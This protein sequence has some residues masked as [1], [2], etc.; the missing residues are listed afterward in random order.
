VE[1]DVPIGSSEEKLCRVAAFFLG[2]VLLA[3]LVSDAS[4]PSAGFIIATEPEVSRSSRR[5]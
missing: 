1:P 2:A 4:A 5:P 3:Q